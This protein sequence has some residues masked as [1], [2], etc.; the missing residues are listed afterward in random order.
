MK[1]KVLVTQSCLTLCN[2]M[3]FSL[4]GNSA[5]GFSRQ[6]HW[7]GGSRSLCQG[8]LPDTGTEPRSP[9]LQADSLPS[10]SP[11]ESYCLD[12]RNSKDKLT[13]NA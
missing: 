10:E 11:E 6:E 13:N 5:M 4:W 1:V 7:S 2:P 12:L 3:D 8:G 9:A